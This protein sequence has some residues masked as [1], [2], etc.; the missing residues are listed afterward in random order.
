M[1]DNANATQ[2]LL[3]PY[4]VLDLTDHRGLLCGKILADL[5]AD[6]VQVEP[7]GGSP[8]RE[9]GPFYQDQVEPEKSF[10]WW[11][12]TTN[13]RGITLDIESTLGQRLLLKLA[14][15]AHFIIESFSPGYL[16]GLGLGY[17][18]LSKTN[19]SLVMVSI[20]P[21]GKDGPYTNYKAPELQ[22]TRHRR[23]RHGWLHVAHWRFRPA[24]S[25][26]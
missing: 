18:A 4:R 12:Y 24:S 21:F 7:P 11:A 6:V 20:S 2:Q 5:G 3:S 23:Y 17:T 1:P 9:L 15:E 19:P 26:G 25:E 14:R 10:F 22:S 8:A 16:D 13:K